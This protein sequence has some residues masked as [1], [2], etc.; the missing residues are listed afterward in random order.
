MFEV[1]LDSNQF[2]LN[3]HSSKFVSNEPLT[4][5]LYLL[6]IQYDGSGDI[7]SGIKYYINGRLDG[8][9]KYYY[10]NGTI[11]QSVNYKKG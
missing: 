9:W 10:I 5:Q 8:Q 4:E 3:T 11:K 2:S 1:G 7:N 6:I